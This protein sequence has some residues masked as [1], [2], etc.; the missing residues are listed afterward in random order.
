MRK[1]S[2]KSRESILLPGALPI[3]AKSDETWQAGRLQQGPCR[4][5]AASSAEQTDAAL[6]AGRFLR[7]TLL[8]TAIVGIVIAAEGNWAGYAE[9]LRSQSPTGGS[10]L[11]YGNVP[12]PNGEAWAVTAND[13]FAQDSNIDTSRWNGGPGGGVW[14]CHS[15]NGDYSD[16]LGHSGP[17][18]TVDNCGQLFGSPSSAPYD[19][20]V[21]GTGLVVQ[22]FNNATEASDW[23]LSDEKQSWMGLTNY[24]HFLQKFGYFEWSAKMPAESNGEGDGLHTDLWCTTEERNQVN[25]SSEVD[26]NE[27]VWGSGVTKTHFSIWE[28]TPGKAPPGANFTYSVSG[29]FSSAFHVYGLYWRNNGLGTYGSMQLYVDGHAQGSPAPLNDPAWNSGI[30]CFAG[31]MQQSPWHDSETGGGP[32][33]SK[34]SNNNPLYVQWWRAWQFQNP[35]APPTISGF[36]AH[37]STIISGDST[38]LTWTVSG[39]TSL[40]IDHGV[41]TVTGQTNIIVSPPVTTPYALTATTGKGQVTRTVTVTVNLSKGNLIEDPGFELQPLPHGDM[42]QPPWYGVGQDVMGVDKTAAECHSGQDCGYITSASKRNGWNA[43]AQT[44]SV[45]PDTNYLLTGWVK[46][47]SNSAFA[48]GEFGVR[49]SGGVI[50]QTSIPPT[51]SYTQLSVSFNSGSKASVVVYA[52]F[53][54]T[55]GGSWLDLDD[56]SLVAKGGTR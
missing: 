1:R 53:T 5:C 39:A 16:D 15:G 8:L 48:G 18:N 43:I 13:T 22:D 34:T 12:P 20:L 54:P 26:V 19:A 56:V 3:A 29:Q 36:L 7:A 50:Q 38:I 2:W 45:V 42:L 4:L 17:L 55:G 32:V 46:D 41:G 35:S 30:Y 9:A 52:G 14:W 27:N 49:T 11:P 21:K 33:D 40:S 6:L 24:G 51:G 37:P 23:S 31:W 25:E 44:V 10:V 47:S 28:N